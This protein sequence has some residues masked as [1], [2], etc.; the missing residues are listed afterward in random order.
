[1]PPKRAYFPKPAIFG[2]M[3][4]LRGR[5]ETGADTNSQ[6]AGIMSTKQQA[7]FTHNAIIIG[8][9]TFPAGYSMDDNGTVDGLHMRH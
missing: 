7:T 9:Q 8:E 2:A 3:I 1:M 4:F 5:C 6:E